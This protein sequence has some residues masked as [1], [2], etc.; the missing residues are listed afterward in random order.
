MR[1]ILTVLSLSLVLSAC[2]TA[3]RLTAA[4]DVHALL[5]AIRDNDRAAFDAK[6]YPYALDR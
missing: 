2:A 3:H 5:V 6:I 1:K 4:N